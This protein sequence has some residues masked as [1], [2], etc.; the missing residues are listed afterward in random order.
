M[1]RKQAL[2][3]YEQHYYKEVGNKVIPIEDPE[4]QKKIDAF[5]QK[6]NFITPPSTSRESGFST[7]SFYGKSVNVNGS[8]L[9]K[10]KIDSDSGDHYLIS[11]AP[12]APKLPVSCLASTEHVIA[13]QE[14]VAD[15]KSEAFPKTKQNVMYLISLSCNAKKVNI[16][17]E[18]KS[19]LKLITQYDKEILKKDVHIIYNKEKA[20]FEI[21]VS[22]QAADI[23]LLV[24]ALTSKTQYKI[25][26]CDFKDIQLNQGVCLVKS[27]ASNPIHALVNIADSEHEKGF[28]ERDAGTTSGSNNESYQDNNWTFNF[29]TSLNDMRKKTKYPENTLAIKI[30]NAK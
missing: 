27:D 19:I 29:F 16:Q 10:K 12:E 20:V 2:T 1:K 17:N 13:M 6:H 28:L 23:Q 15:F 21:T 25:V 9:K 11:R 5:M 24:R 7:Y 3:G 26:D 8:M 22:T 18:K 4:E 14:L 30:F